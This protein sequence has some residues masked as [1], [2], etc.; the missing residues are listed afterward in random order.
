MKLELGAQSI[1]GGDIDMEYRKNGREISP[2]TS[3]SLRN[4][5]YKCFDQC[6]AAL[7]FVDA[8]QDLL[9]ELF[10]DINKKPECCKKHT[11]D[12]ED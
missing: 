9:D 7:E 6:E 8:V 4:K 5:C 3:N 12:Y 1:L 2:E 10:G 11:R